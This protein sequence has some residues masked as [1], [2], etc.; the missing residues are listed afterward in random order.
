MGNDWGLLLSFRWIT[1]VYVFSHYIYILT[2]RHSLYN[3]NEIWSLT[4]HDKNNFSLHG[5][6]RHWVDD[7]L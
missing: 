7:R 6:V 1:I 4:K 3:K 2:A 5:A